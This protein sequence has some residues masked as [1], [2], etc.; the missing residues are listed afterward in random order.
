[1]GSQSTIAHT[2]DLLNRVQ[3]REARQEQREQEQNQREQQQAQRDQQQAQRDHKQN[4]RD[5]KQEQREFRLDRREKEQ[6]L[7]EVR[8]MKGLQQQLRS[9]CT[10][11][12]IAFLQVLVSTLKQARVA[13]V[14]GVVAYLYYLFGDKVKSWWG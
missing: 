9:Y 2:T 4:Q 8:I 6:I 1:M 7:S 3:R 5:Q 10:S 14:L 11:D 13:F 12:L